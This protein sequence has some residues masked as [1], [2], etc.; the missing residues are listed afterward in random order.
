M[1]RSLYPACMLLAV[2]GASLALAGDPDGVPLRDHYLKVRF[3][4]AGEGDIIYDHL[5][6]S[7]G[8]IEFWVRPDFDWLDSATHHLFFWGRRDN[9]KS[10]FVTKIKGRIYFFLCGAK[11]IGAGI[12]LNREAHGLLPGTWHHIACCWDT[13]DGRTHR[14][15]FLNGECADSKEFDNR[16]EREFRGISKIPTTMYIGTGKTNARLMTDVS[17]QLTVSQ[18]RISDVVRYDAAFTPAR[19]FAVDAH[20]LVYF[21]FTG[22]TLT[23]LYYRDGMS[24]GKV[25]A[26]R[27]GIE[28]QGGFVP[29]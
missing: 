3:A 13:T 18:F 26:E 22:G 7:R 2:A 17:P 8:T 20:T 24:P 4:S 10:I 27:I 9:A 23:G 19:E 1:N 29:K 21:P 6:P 15:I 28:P 25:D 5:N 11:R 16:P 14:R 12:R